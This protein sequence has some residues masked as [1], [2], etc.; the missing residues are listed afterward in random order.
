MVVKATVRRV[1]DSY[2]KLVKR[3]PLI[4]IRDEAHLDEAIAFLSD[5]LRAG[6][7][8]GD[9]GIPG[10]LDRSGCRLRGRAHSD[11]DVSEAD[12]L[13]ELMPL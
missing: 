2:L 10:C 7:R 6:A 3:F 4:H 5:L 1:P 11:A 13:R 9:A 12:V 8:S